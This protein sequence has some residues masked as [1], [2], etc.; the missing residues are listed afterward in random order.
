MYLFRRLAFVVLLATGALSC[1]FGTAPAADTSAP[2]VV[3]T[4][5]AGTAVSGTITF[6]AEVIDDTG[7]ANVVFKVDDKTIA[8]DGLPPYQTTWASNA[9]ADGTHRLAVTGIDVTG[10]TTTVSKSVTVTN[11]PE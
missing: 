2:V 10:K 8:E 4:S 9:A 7:V 3:I 1:G 5:P 11:N 6:S